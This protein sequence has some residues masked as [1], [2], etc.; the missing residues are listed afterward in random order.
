MNEKIKT[1]LPQHQDYMIQ[2]WTSNSS[3]LVLKKHNK[4]L[5]SI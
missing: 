4:I 1:Y 5:L 2:T 3:R